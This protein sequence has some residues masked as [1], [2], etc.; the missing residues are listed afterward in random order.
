[1]LLIEG[2][3]KKPISMAISVKQKEGERGRVAAGI[4]ELRCSVVK[5]RV[6]V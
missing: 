5:K 2:R 4:R 1:M 6:R 3:K